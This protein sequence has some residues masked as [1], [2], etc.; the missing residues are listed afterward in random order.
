MDPK[1]LTL[2]Q[3]CSLATGVCVSLL[4]LRNIFHRVYRKIYKY[5]PGLF[6]IP[7]FGS[8]FTVAFYQDDYFLS[9]ILP[10]YGPITMFRIG[11][12]NMISINDATLVQTILEHKAS[13]ER[14]PQLADLFTLK[15]NKYD[16]Y[17]N[18]TNGK[19]ETLVSDFCFGGAEW[20]VSVLFVLFVCV[21]CF[22]CVVFCLHSRLFSFCVYVCLLLLCML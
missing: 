10:K 4:L 7:Y 2:L 5:P 22:C 21:F 6:G 11:N 20:Y 19:N 16:D 15:I 3:K 12:T 8:F 14:P 1:R 9:K 13:T 17:D 18:K